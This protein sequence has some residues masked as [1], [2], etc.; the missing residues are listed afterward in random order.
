MAAPGRAVSGRAYSSVRART[1]DR[2]DRRRHGAHAFVCIL[3]VGFRVSGQ[4][5]CCKSRGTYVLSSVA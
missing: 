2:L 4:H 1:P 3:P 5:V